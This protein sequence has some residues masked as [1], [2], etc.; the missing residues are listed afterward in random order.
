MGLFESSLSKGKLIS[1]L[2]QTYSTFLHR[3][4]EADEHQINVKTFAFL[5]KDDFLGYILSLSTFEILIVQIG[6]DLRLILKNG[7]I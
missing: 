6:K 1:N 5:E 4:N 3:K 7:Q 2:R